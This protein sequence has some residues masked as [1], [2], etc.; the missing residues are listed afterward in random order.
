[1]RI[2]R[3]AFLLCDCYAA[4]STCEVVKLVEE[5]EFFVMQQ[6]LLR[7]AEEETIKLEIN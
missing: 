2:Q 5:F 3:P 7:N 4:N 6:D 1:M